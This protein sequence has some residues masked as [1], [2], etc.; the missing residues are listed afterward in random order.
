MKK[1]SEM[2]IN[3]KRRR[4]LKNIFG[5]SGKIEIEEDRIVGL[6]SKLSL[7]Y[8]YKNKDAYGMCLCG[9]DSKKLSLE[10]REYFSKK[11]IYYVFEDIVFDK[12]VTVETFFDVNVIFRNC[13]FNDYV[14]LDGVS[15]IVFENNKYITL[16]NQG[17]EFFTGY[18]K[19]I[20]FIDDN[21]VNSDNNVNFGMD[22]NFN[23]VEFVDSNIE[24]DKKS[25]SKFLVKAKELLL[26][27][28]TID[29]PY[30]CFNCEDIICLDDSVIGANKRI[31]VNNNIGNFN[32][33]SVIAPFVIHNGSLVRTVDSNKSK[34]NLISSR[35]K[36]IEELKVISRYFSNINN[37]EIKKTHD[38][39]NNRSI[40]RILSK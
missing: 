6:V 2:I 22:I 18:G 16:N 39:I 14:R 28:V 9:Y 10:D 19:N 36:L 12:G 11:P 40:K 8:T 34:N 25:N 1:I 20:E 30:I 23:V 27:N 37:S 32:I 38:D 21:F 4:I 24:I 29:C 3:F 33:M 13:T 17:K 31:D 15:N 5:F 35:Q 26:D 7:N